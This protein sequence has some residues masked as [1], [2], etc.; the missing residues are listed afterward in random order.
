MRDKLGN[1]GFGL[2]TALLVVLLLTVL[3]FG[4]AGTS[5]LNLHLMTRTGN[6]HQADN[7]A[8][9]VVARAIEE[10]LTSQ[11]EDAERVD[12]LRVHPEGA[13]PEAEGLLCFDRAQAEKLGI[14]WSTDNREGTV[15]IQGWRDRPVAPGAV[16]LVGVGRAN[17]I[18]HRIEAVLHSPGFPWAIAC[19]GPIRSEGGVTVARLERLPENRVPTVEDYLP[20]DVVSNAPGESVYLG[21]HTTISGDVR[22]VG[23]VELASGGESIQ[24]LGEVRT[25]TDPVELPEIDPA[26]YDPQAA[27]RPYEELH[28]AHYSE[29]PTVFEGS[30]RRSGSITVQGGLEL[31]G[32][33]VYV[34][35]DL[36]VH[37]GLSGRGILVVRGKTTIVGGADLTSDNL[38]LLSEGDVVLH[39]KGKD[40]S[41]FHGLVY[42]KG[43]FL[44][45]EITLLGTLVAGGGQQTGGGQHNGATDRA[46]RATFRDA[47]MVNLPSSARVEVQPGA[48]VMEEGIEL[49]LDPLRLGRGPATLRFKP[50]AGGGSYKAELVANGSRVQDVIEFGGG[51]SAEYDALADL[52]TQAGLSGSKVPKVVRKLIGIRQGV[53]QEYHLGGDLGEVVVVDPSQ[54]IDFSQSAR[55]LYWSSI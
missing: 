18:E 25:N 35:G 13:P 14:P 46:P 16:Y 31:S 9:C 42:T 27:G 8:R 17:G 20:A 51:G 55:L 44:A 30:L 54:F 15:S 38:A 29:G 12:T 41:F 45:E 19:A 28:E 34:D 40:R 47:A 52:L 2:G 11:D 7:V 39:G 32:A 3:A 23:D 36:T 6:S 4:L 1:R 22:A 5:V 48:A 53:W 37:G 50:D 33:V 49:D 43:N 24:V 21:S 26:L 10:I